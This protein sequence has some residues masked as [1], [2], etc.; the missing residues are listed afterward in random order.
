MQNPNG[1]MIEA[2]TTDEIGNPI[3]GEVL[4]PVEI[5]EQVNIKINVSP[6]TPFDRACNRPTA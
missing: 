3:M 6:A 2:E 4:I 5:L 1:M